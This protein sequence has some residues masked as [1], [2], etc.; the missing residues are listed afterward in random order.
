M[1]LR[2][3]EADW[4]DTGLVWDLEKECGAA[5]GLQGSGQPQCGGAPWPTAAAV[6]RAGGSAE[7]DGAQRQVWD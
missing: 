2:S 3:G 4:M 6:C 7:G 1:F 5:V